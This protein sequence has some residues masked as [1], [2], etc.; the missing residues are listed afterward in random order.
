MSNQ[1]TVDGRSFVSRSVC[2][3]IIKTFNISHKI[4]KHEKSIDSMYYTQ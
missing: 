2:C 3:V 4:P 1:K